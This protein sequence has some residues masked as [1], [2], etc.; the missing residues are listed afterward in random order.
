MVQTAQG[1]EADFPATLAAHACCS[2][3]RHE[4][5]IKHLQL[6]L[7]EDVRPFCDPFILPDLV[8]VRCHIGSP[9]AEK[10]PWAEVGALLLQLTASAACDPAAGLLCWPCRKDLSEAA[11]WSK[12]AGQA[13][14][15]VQGCA[16][17]EDS[18]MPCCGLQA[19]ASIA[20][21]LGSKGSSGHD[22]QE[23][24]RL[25]HL[26][27]NLAY[28][29][30]EAGDQVQVSRDHLLQAVVSPNQSVVIGVQ[31]LV[32]VVGCPGRCTCLWSRVH[33]RPAAL[34]SMLMPLRASTGLPVPPTWRACRRGTL[35]TK[36]WRWIRGR[37]SRTSCS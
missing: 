23:H 35:R 17:R 8:L 34:P 33:V 5:A 31:S 24:S 20:E 37:W 30:S 7:P 21:L 28:V 26:Y 12:D 14:A 15:W 18:N 10:F 25:R 2:L 19:D 13:L 22:Q 4:D 3:G 27:H 6:L 9:A 16:P 32:C 29:A 1:A 36:L 11:C